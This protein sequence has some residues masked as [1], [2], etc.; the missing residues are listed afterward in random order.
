MKSAQFCAWAEDQDGTWETDC[1]GAF[2]V[3]DGTPHENR[4]AFC[5]YCGRELDQY[6][7]A[8]D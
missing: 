6:P 1:G 8:D 5:P 2:V 3:N 4:M 7:Y